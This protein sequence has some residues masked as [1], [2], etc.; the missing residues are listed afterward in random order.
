MANVLYAEWTSSKEID[1]ITDEVTSIISTRATSERFSY[2]LPTL[3]IRFTGTGLDGWID[4]WINWNTSVGTS[5]LPECIGRVDTEEPTYY[6]VSP[7]TVSPNSYTFF[8]HTWNLFVKL[9]R[10]GQFAVRFTPR[11]GDTITAIFDLHGMTAAAREAGF[12]INLITEQVDFLNYLTEIRFTETG[13]VIT[14]HLTNLQWHLGPD[15]D[16][17]WKEAYYWSNSLAGNWRLPYLAELE[18]LFHGEIGGCDWNVFQFQGSLGQHELWSTAS[19]FSNA[20]CIGNYPGANRQHTRRRGHSSNLRAIAVRDPN[21]TDASRNMN[22]SHVDSLCEYR[23]KK[24]DEFITDNRTVLTWQVGPDYDMYMDEADNWVSALGGNWRLPT[25]EE[26]TEL[27]DSGIEYGNW[28]Q[29]SNSGKWLWSSTTTPWAV[30]FCENHYADIN[31]HGSPEQT[32]TNRRVFA[33]CNRYIKQENIITDIVTNLQWI[34]GPDSSTNWNDANSWVN[35]LG[36][37]WRLPSIDELS[38]LYDTGIYSRAWGHFQNEGSYVWAMQPD[39][40]SSAWTFRPPAGDGLGGG[41][42]FLG[43]NISQFDNARAFAVR[44]L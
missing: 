32:N 17:N 22:S 23:F 11:G 18:Q 14:D 34:V 43:E 21:A 2:N 15:S 8:P 27:Y 9:I 25:T 26:L 1:P 13:G 39:G 42:S 6:A 44:S 20:W 24:I 36:N 41:Y 35:T 31:S 38:T 7:S 12:Q 16:T 37:G 30:N 19:G 29:F 4:I 33:V 28:G 5:N 10:G 3:G 40:S